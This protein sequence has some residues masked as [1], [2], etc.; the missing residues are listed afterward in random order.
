MPGSPLPFGASTPSDPVQHELPPIRYE[1]ELVPLRVEIRRGEDGTWRGRLLFGAQPED[2]PATA[3][4]FCA[5]TEADLWECVR[6]LREHHL[7]DLYRL[8]AE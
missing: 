6:D 8:V 1:G 5:V 4:I 7:R 2:P 3:E